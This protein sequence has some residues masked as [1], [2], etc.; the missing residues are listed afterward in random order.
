[1]NQTDNSSRSYCF[2][3]LCSDFGFRISDSETRRQKEGGE[4]ENISTVHTVHT[5]HVIVSQKHG[6][7]L[8][9]KDVFYSPAITY[10]GRRAYYG[11]VPRGMLGEV[12]PK[13]GKEGCDG[14][15]VAASREG[16][17][18]TEVHDVIS[19][20][21][22][23]ENGARGGVWLIALRNLSS[24]QPTNRFCAFARYMGLADR[25]MI[26]RGTTN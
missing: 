26:D 23:S 25:Q 5:T 1:M 7:I 20:G 12:T 13:K 2:N 18:T 11:I 24:S 17:S 10:D 14:V 19:L 8:F 21:E 3:F 22:K 4:E 6:V 9:V 16:G 15:P